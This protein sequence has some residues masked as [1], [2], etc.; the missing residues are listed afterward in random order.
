MGLCSFL[1]RVSLLAKCKLIPQI[2][3]CSSEW[4]GRLKCPA[5]GLDRS[6]PLYFTSS[7]SSGK[8]SFNLA[9]PDL[10]S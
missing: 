1:F 3:M 9:Q 4:P 6:D 8:R 5:T 10:V 2:S 7:K